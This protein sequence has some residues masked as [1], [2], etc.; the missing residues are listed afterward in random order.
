VTWQTLEAEI[1]TLHSCHSSFFTV[2]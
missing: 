1:A 2:I